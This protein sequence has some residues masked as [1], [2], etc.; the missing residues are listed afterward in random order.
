MRTSPPA[1]A[2]RLR[3]AGAALALVLALALALTASGCA[4][5]P[6]NPQEVN[7]DSVQVTERD[8]EVARQMQAPEQV[9]QSLEQGEWL[10]PSDREA[11]RFAE[12]ALDHMQDAYGQECRAT[13]STVPWILDTNATVTLVAVGGP[14]DG[15]EV[16]VTISAAEPHTYTDT[17]YQVRHQSEY[18]TLVANALA[19]AFTDLP[20]DSWAFG[21]SLPVPGEAPEDAQLTELEDAFGDISLYLLSTEVPDAT[22]L[23][24]LR[25]AA[26]TE[27][28]KIGIES[29]V[30][31]FVLD[32]AKVQPPFTSAEGYAAVKAGAAVMT[33]SGR[34]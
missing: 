27:L 10:Y 5:S 34:A 26:L 24:E 32:S 33:D 25:Q 8:L 14:Y 4:F 3:R 15:A 21:T 9:I 11:V 16:E 6:R 28:E 23:E 30:G 20:A 13:W 17:W 31:F 29:Y 7:V 18:K 1:R 22:R 2:P 19:T 12:L